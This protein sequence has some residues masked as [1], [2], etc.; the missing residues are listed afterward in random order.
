[1]HNLYFVDE[2]ADSCATQSSQ[3]SKTSL[4][5]IRIVKYHNTEI[6]LLGI[7]GRWAGPA[8]VWFRGPAAKSIFVNTQIGVLSGEKW[9]EHLQR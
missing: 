8:L 6:S 7:Y 4:T 3:V 2:K 5:Q 1:M 9:I